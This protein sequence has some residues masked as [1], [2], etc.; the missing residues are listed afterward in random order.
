MLDA[1]QFMLNNNRDRHA[2]RELIDAYAYEEWADEVADAPEFSAT[3]MRVI[4]LEEFAERYV[5]LP[6]VE[7]AADITDAHLFAL[8]L[9]GYEF[10]TVGIYTHGDSW[11]STDGAGW[12]WSRVNGPHMHRALATK[13]GAVHHAWK[14]YAGTL[15]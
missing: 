3:G 15:A 9:A 1:L 14:D 10:F 2:Q 6:K 8:E 7:S 11:A 13:Q 5:D 4:E 12:T